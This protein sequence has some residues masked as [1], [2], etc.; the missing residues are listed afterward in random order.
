MST[1]ISSISILCFGKMISLFLFIKDSCV[2]KEVMEA[3]DDDFGI[4]PDIF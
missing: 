3:D 2:F 1:A 4:F